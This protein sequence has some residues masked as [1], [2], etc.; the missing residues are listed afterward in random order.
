MPHLSLQARLASLVDRLRAA[1]A[2][3]AAEAEFTDD[4][5]PELCDMLMAT[6]LR[7]PVRLPSS[8]KVIDR[9]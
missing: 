3:T 6:L 4:A 7:D 9:R 2:A 8:R 1:A 5:P